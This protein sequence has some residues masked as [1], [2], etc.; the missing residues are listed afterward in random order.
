MKFFTLIFVLAT[1]VLAW[2]APADISTSDRESGATIIE[3]CRSASVLPCTLTSI[4][5]PSLRVGSMATCVSSSLD[6]QRVDTGPAGTYLLYGY[7]NSCGKPAMVFLK[8]ANKWSEGEILSKGEWYVR[9]L[10]NP[11]DAVA[12]PG[13]IMFCPFGKKPKDDTGCD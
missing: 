11:G 10:Y 7:K 4:L 5:P 3:T 12:S 9:I 2:A 6:N 1:P 13:A 8:I